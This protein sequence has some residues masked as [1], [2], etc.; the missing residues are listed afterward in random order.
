MPAACARCLFGEAAWTGPPTYAFALG[1]GLDVAVARAA[2]DAWAAANIET[3]ATAFCGTCSRVCW[4]A[5]RDCAQ[6]ALLEHTALL[7]SLASMRKHHDVEEPDG[8]CT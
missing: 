8:G 4:L 5:R 6:G 1:M 3:G 2:A 7:R